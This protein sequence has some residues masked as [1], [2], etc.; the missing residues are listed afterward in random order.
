MGLISFV[1]AQTPVQKEAVI[2]AMKEALSSDEFK[3][4]L[5]A[6]ISGSSQTEQEL[7]KKLMRQNMMQLAMVSNA[8]ITKYLTDLNKP[9]E[10]KPLMRKISDATKKALEESATYY[11]PQI[12]STSVVAIIGYSI[13]S[14]LPLVGPFIRFVVRSVLDTVVKG[15]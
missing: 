7:Y 11:V 4:K 1:A 2:N 6:M 5:Q 8:G 3:E 14:R 13:V 10:K 9:E 12:V 15:S